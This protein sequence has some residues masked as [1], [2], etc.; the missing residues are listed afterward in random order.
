MGGFFAK[1]RE[2]LFGKRKSLE[3]VANREGAEESGEVQAEHAEPSVP[4]A[5]QSPPEPDSEPEEVGKDFAESPL[6]P[7]VPADAP[8]AA[9]YSEPEE[10]QA[11]SVRESMVPRIHT[12]ESVAPEPER[13][14]YFV[15]IGLDFGTA[16]CKCVC[17]DVMLEKAWVHIHSG[18]SNAEMPFLIPSAIRL[19]GN[20]LR[21]LTDADGMYGQGSLHHV[22]MA[23][24]KVALGKWDDPVLRPY[25]TAAAALDWDTA[26][27]VEMCAVY[28]LGR[29]L[30]NVKR[31]VSERFRGTVSGDY[32][33]VNLAVP[34]ADAD[35]PRICTLF[36][37]VLRCAWAVADDLGSRRGAELAALRTLVDR[38]ADQIQSEET[39]EMC[40]CYP[41]VS[42]NVQGFVRSRTSSPGLYLFS[43]TGA[44]TVDQ[45]VFLFARP[46]GED[47]LTYLHAEVFPLGSYFIER[48]AAGSEGDESWENLERWRAEKER[49]GDNGHMRSARIWVAKQLAQGTE[50]TICQAKQKLRSKA[51][52]NG[53][54]VIFGGGGH[55]RNPYGEAV[56]EQF[57]GSLFLYEKIQQRRGSEGSLEIGMPMPADIELPDGVENRWINRLTVAYGLSF[58]KGQLARFKLPSEMRVPPPEDVWRPI[59]EYR[60][61]TK[62][63]V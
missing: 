54:R 56:L 3:P 16:F 28:L 51:Q 50:R 48:H 9:Q 37:R 35:S 33:A 62:D 21:P 14:P 7:P 15:Q 26:E 34:V 27:L 63:E 4:D 44:G 61:P 41:E 25:K 30:G 60:A 36:E 29:V 40:C 23:L 55:C 22:K 45:S 43:D 47:Q 39:A 18:Q 46:Y 58:E 12:E 24:E 52:I 19:D 5:P 20:V 10:D 6:P 57:N 13:D 31:D 42:A 32:I 11:R 49:G 17:R 38:K 2:R 59:Q 1:L 53:L 8:P